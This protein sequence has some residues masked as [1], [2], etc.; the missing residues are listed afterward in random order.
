MN[1]QSNALKFTREG[2][3]INISC[4]LIKGIEEGKKP[5]KSKL[6]KQF[7]DS[8]SSGDDSNNPV[9]LSA[10]SNNSDILKFE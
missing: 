3:S 9:N 8:F 10:D 1:L 4:E 6:E 2:G 7:N 5:S